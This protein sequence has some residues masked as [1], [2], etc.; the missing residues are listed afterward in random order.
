MPGKAK[1]IVVTGGSGRLGVYTIRELIAAGYE[2]LSL[3]VVAPEQ[4]VC[5]SWFCDLK[6]PGDI[7]QALKNADAV[8]HLAAFQ[9]PNLVSDCETFNNNTT[10]SYNILK[11]AV[12]MGVR[13]VVLASSVA[14]YGFVYAPKMWVPDYLPLDE[15][16]PCKPQDPY[17][18]SKVFGEQL[19]DSFTTGN[20]LTAVSLRLS[21]VNFDLT[22]KTLPERWL[23]PGDKIGTFWSYI[24][25][26]DAAIACLLAVEANIVGHQ[27][28][29]ISTVT[30][31]YPEPTAELIQ[32][33]LPETKIR[34]GFSGMWGGLDCS[35]AKKTLGFEAKYVWQKYL[36]KDGRLISPN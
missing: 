11:A 32:R 5:E 27:I 29:N 10:S 6:N 3:D 26:R 34:E 9:A 8:I 28:L 35:L 7:F 24:D 2:V 1:K 16:Y 25:V 15:K 33:Y 18:L 17:G 14:A 12:D 19:A 30:S 21:G 31:R 13:R 22:Y 36:D 4:K 23:N 20:P